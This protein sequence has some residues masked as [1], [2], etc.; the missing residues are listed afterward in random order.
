MKTH[1]TISFLLTGLLATLAAVG[2]GCV[3]QRPARNGVFNENQYLRKDFLVS[4]LGAKDPGWFMKATIT[5]TSQPNPLGGAFIVPGAE[6]NGLGHG[7]PLVRFKITNDK[8]QLINMKEMFA[9]QKIKDKDGVER[10]DTSV[11]RTPEV[12][13]AWPISN[14]DL[15]YRINLD[16]EKSNFYEENQEL[17]WQVRQWVKLNLNKNDMSDVV[18]MGSFTHEFMDLCTDQGNSSTTLVPNS[19]IV[20]ENAGYMEWV[21]N[22]TVPL[23]VTD[24]ACRAFFA[25]SGY[26]DQMINFD[27]M[28]RQ[29]V[30][31]NMMYSFVRAS[32]LPAPADPSNPAATPV[33]EEAYEP[34]L[35][36]E[37]DPIQ[38]KYG[39]LSIIA[40]ARDLD[41]QLVG[42]RQYVARFNPKKKNLTWYFAK[43]FPE[44]FKT[45]FTEPGGIVEGTNKVFE[46]AGATMRLEVKDWNADGI[47]RHYGD[48]RYNFIRWVTGHE[49]G[50]PYLGVMQG[51]ADPR[52]GEF[53]SVS[54]NIADFP[55]KDFV[56][57]RIDAFLQTLGVS[58]QDDK[59]NT[60]IDSPGAWIDESEPC[61]YEGQSKF[62][63]WQKA[64]L[65]PAN[66]EEAK[67]LPKNEFHV[68]SSLFRKMQ[69]YLNRPKGSTVD[70]VAVT[71]LGPRDFI[72]QWDKAGKDKDFMDAYFKTIPYLIFADPDSNPYVIREGGSGVYS[73][74]LKPVWDMSRKEAEFLRLS[75]AI[76]RG[77]TPYS[78]IDGPHGLE[79]LLSFV[80]KYRDLMINHRKFEQSLWKLHDGK[81]EAADV[82]SLD[83]TTARNARRCIKDKDGNLRWQTK[84][85]W[86]DDIIRVYWKLV[87]WHEF[88]HALGLSH[89]FMGSVDSHNFP[90]VKDADGNEQIQYYS[91]SVMEYN[92]TADRALYGAGWGPYDQGAIAWIYSNKGASKPATAATT[93]L[94][95]QAANNDPW[96]DPLGFRDD[97]SEIQFLF[98]DERHVTYTPLCRRHDHGVTPSEITANDISNYEWGYQFRNFR[99][100]RKFWNNGSYVNGPVNLIMDLR[101]FMSLWGYD[102]DSASL[103]NTFRRIGVP[104]PT[105][106]GNAAIYYSQLASK[107]NRE[108]SS[109]NQITAAFHKAV[110]QQSSGER[111]FRTIYDKYYGDTTQQGIILDKLYAMIGWVGLWPTDNYDQNQAGGYISSYSML[112]DSQFASIAQDAVLSMVGGQYDAYRYFVPF[113]V[114]LYAQDTHSTSFGGRVEMRDWVGGFVFD[115]VRHFLEFFRD[116]A[117]TNHTK[118][119]GEPHVSDDISTCG[120]DP[121]DPEDA[122]TPYEWR[123]H[124]E[125]MGPDKR[126]WIWSYV[127]DRNQYV[128]VRKDRHVASY[129]IMRNYN[130]SVVYQLDDGTYP[131]NAYSRLL[132]VKYFLDSFRM[133]N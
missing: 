26:G 10:V 8:L 56:A 61:R 39:P 82:V 66:E 19:F 96:N 1:N 14:V 102:W 80:N 78:E 35:V 51:Q 129:L 93:S 120:Y 6:S 49:T 116:M 83:Q 70:G 18:P 95:G 64:L 40:A 42:A 63:Q 67:K 103:V 132:P 13:N 131:G 113:A 124:N 73:P 118:G 128:A 12:V 106:G 125:F 59:G 98:C 32:P 16:G 57:H 85:E 11:Q 71:D 30:S 97:G 43:D 108:A 91:S 112:G 117:I 4:P 99:K 28:D 119:C 123:K 21:I 46:K 100:H 111:P 62:A 24:D 37:K 58:G 130:D 65:P 101:R 110:I 5:E 107:F 92:V 50:S 94:S 29:S 60:G 77:E 25:G 86:L 127:Q 33:N 47:E 122:D 52:T 88:G 53:I 133:F 34:L 75:A 27:L 89:N 22:V 68:K 48:V 41:S 121:R 109:A 45:F 54:I 2:P 81:F 55:A 84:D 72:A 79:N 114:S 3:S 90:K 87:I 20:D 36:D 31:F 7:M 126:V 23:R 105:K 104:D 74:D 17:D 44:D 38:H 69:E 115:D 9:E 76:D 15:K